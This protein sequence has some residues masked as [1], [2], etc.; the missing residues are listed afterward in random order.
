MGRG[1]AALA[2]VGW[3]AAPASADGLARFEAAIKQAPDGAFTYKSAKALGDNGFVVEG[4]TV[5]PPPEATQGAKTQPIDI[6]RI[7]V[8]DFDFAAV[9]NNTPPLYARVRVEGIV[10]DAYLDLSDLSVKGEGVTL[11]TD[12]LILGEAPL[13]KV[14][15]STNVND[16]RFQR[17][18]DI[19]EALEKMRLEANKL[20]VAVV[21]L[22][23]FAVQTGYRLPKGVGV[24][25]GA[26]Y[27]YIRPGETLSTPEKETPKKSDKKKEEK[28]NYYRS[29][30]SYGQFYRLV[31]L[32]EGIDPEK[33]K[34]QFRDG[35][36][37][38]EIPLPPSAQRKHKEIPIRT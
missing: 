37:Q 11:K 31:P 3:L 28:K 5:T 30:R 32:P 4:V 17:K 34:A 9:D 27:D 25:G 23:R 35:V 6:K 29:E 7:A 13:D 10:I 18:K 36:L 2:L 8:E 12:Y 14:S 24:G 22:R 21:P 19:A 1:V 26:G 16:P 15:A 20:G 38:V 33:A